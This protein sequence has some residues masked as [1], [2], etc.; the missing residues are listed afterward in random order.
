MC[1]RDSA[2]HVG[3]HQGQQGIHPA[4]LADD[5]VLGDHGHL[6]GHHEHH[7]QH[8]EQRVP[9]G[10]AHAGKGEGRKGAQEHHDDGNQNGDQDGVAVVAQEIQP[11]VTGKTGYFPR[12][13]R[14]S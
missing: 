9:Q 8:V 3:H 4:Q 10:E 5:E 7:Q 11:Y 13:D 1:I 6:G 12:E 14:L 2:E